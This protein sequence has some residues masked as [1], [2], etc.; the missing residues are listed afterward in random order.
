MDALTAFICNFLVLFVSP[1]PNDISCS[2][3]QLLANKVESGA[4]AVEG[5]SASVVPAENTVPLSKLWSS[6]LLGLILSG[7]FPSVKD[8]KVTMS[9]L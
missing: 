1:Y 5:P 9:S 6:D 4:S 3:L 8:V 7:R 2:C